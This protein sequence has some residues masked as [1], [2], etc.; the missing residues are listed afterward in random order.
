MLNAEEQ[1]HSSIMSISNSNPGRLVTFDLLVTARYKVANDDGILQ[2]L[3][4]LKS[5][6]NDAD[7]NEI[8]SILSGK[9]DP[10]MCQGVEY[11][12]MNV[13]IDGQSAPHNIRIQPIGPDDTLI[14]SMN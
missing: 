11:D 10:R 3:R 6:V 2:A 12:I 8:Y 4:I 5:D 13:Y 1:V 14:K 9:Q 7:L